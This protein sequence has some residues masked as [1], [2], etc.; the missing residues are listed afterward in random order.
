MNVGHLF[1]LAG[2]GFVV[3][4]VLAGRERRRATVSPPA[5]P[6]PGHRTAKSETA[7]AAAL[8]EFA[9]APVTEPT[10]TAATLPPPNP[11]PA[12]VAAVF[13]A[14]VVDRVTGGWVPVLEVRH[15]SA[16]GGA[17]RHCDITTVR[18]DRAGTFAA[19]T[20]EAHRMRDAYLADLSWGDRR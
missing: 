1:L 20:A 3:T 9:S 12:P 14:A 10:P 6:W 17:A 8:A 4:C 15:L 5:E 19:A 16:A 18:G 11:G 2:V 13:P 7:A